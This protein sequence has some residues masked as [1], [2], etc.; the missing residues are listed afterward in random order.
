MAAKWPKVFKLIAALLALLLVFCGH[1]V[2]KFRYNTHQ[3]VVNV[4]IFGNY[5]P[6]DVV[7][8]FTKETG[9]KINI[10]ECASNEA[11]LAKLQAGGKGSYDLVVPSSYY[12]SKMVKFNMLQSINF[13]KVPN[14]R[15]VLKFLQDPALNSISK[16]NIPYCWGTTGIAVNDRHFNLKK[17]QAWRDLWSLE[18]LNQLM[19]LDDMRE[20]FSIALLKLGF[21]V[22]DENPKHIKLAYE[23]LKKLWPNIRT[24]NAEGIATLYLDEDAVIGNAWSGDIVLAQRANRHVAYVYPEEGCVLWFDGLAILKHAKHQANA[25]K[26]INFMLRPDISFKISQR[27]GFA[28]ANQVAYQKFS[29]LNQD[30]SAA[31]LSQQQLKKCQVQ[32]ELSDTVRQIYE[33]YWEKLRL[34]N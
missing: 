23:E 13:N 1:R 14:Y 12:I 29:D 34:G 27:I 2:I 10:T 22:N 9:I 7:K 5:L 8:Q 18:F 11:L 3:N 19:L 33:Y 25:Y 17:V 28:S 15:Y 21:S 20:S 6:E 31:Q 24:F 16:F 30:L 32:Q 4:C 26:L